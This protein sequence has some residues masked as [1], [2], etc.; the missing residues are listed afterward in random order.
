MKDEI[1]EFGGDVNGGG[2]G[3]PRGFERTNDIDSVAWES[4]DETWSQEEFQTYQLGHLLLSSRP[5]G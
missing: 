1:V 2:R 3:S 4:V 5:E